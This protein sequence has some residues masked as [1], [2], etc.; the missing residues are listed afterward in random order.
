[1]K[2]RLRLKLIGQRFRTNQ[3]VHWTLKPAEF[4]S[5]NKYFSEIPS[6][7]SLQEKLFLYW[8]AKEWV[9]G[10]LIVELGPFLGGTTRALAKGAMDNTNEVKVITIDQFES[11]YTA[12]QFIEMNVPISH[13]YALDDKINFRSIFNSYHEKEPY[14]NLIETLNMKVAENKSESTS[15]N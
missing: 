1:M 11:Y 6:E 2:L 12:K 7:T 13:D 4:G 15:M 14:F 3:I 9:K 10:G 8:L 5:L